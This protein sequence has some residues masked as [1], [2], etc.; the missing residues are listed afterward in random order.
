MVKRFKSKKIKKYE[1]AINAKVLIKIIGNVLFIISKL[2]L[3]KSLNIYIYI[4]ILPLD[5]SESLIYEDLLRASELSEG[6][7]EFCEY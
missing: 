6:C 2:E 4:Q 7:R 1:N 5:T 3:I